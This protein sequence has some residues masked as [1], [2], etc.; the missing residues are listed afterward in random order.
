MVREY[1]GAGLAGEFASEEDRIEQERREAEDLRR[2]REL[3]R[4]EDLAAPLE[5]LDDLA[6]TLARASLVSGGYHRRRGEWRMRR[7]A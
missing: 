2:R 7:D 5:E 1:I 6:A 3:E 4:P